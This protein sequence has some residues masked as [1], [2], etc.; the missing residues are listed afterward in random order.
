[1]KDL[2]WFHQIDE[3]NE[4]V[5]IILFNTV[6]KVFLLRTVNYIVLCSK[7]NIC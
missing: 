4:V 7:F 5:N 3:L 1:L 6:N 2:K